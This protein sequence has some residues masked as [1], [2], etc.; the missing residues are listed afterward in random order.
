MEAADPRKELMRLVV[1]SAA[2]SPKARPAWLPEVLP[3]LADSRIPWEIRRQATARLL[4]L[5]PDRLRYVRPLLQALTHGLTSQQKWECLRW[6]QEAVPRCHALDRWLARWDQRRRW[7]CPRCQRYLPRP[8]FVTHLWHVH[9]LIYDHQRRRVC[10]PH[11]LARLAARRW[12]QT[13]QNAELDQVW[14]W[15]GTAG[16]RRCLRS[17]ATTPEDWHALLGQAGVRHQGLCPRCLTELPASLPP[18]LPPLTVTTHRLST[19]DWCV[20]IL[21]GPCWHV[22]RVR[23]PDQDY[24]LV[25]IRPSPRLLACLAAL[26]AAAVVLI[27]VPARLV[28]WPLLLIS[29]TIY[30]LVRFLLRHQADR[31]DQLI[32]AAW[33]YLVPQARLDRDDHLR[34]LTRLCQASM[35]QGSPAVR[36]DVLYPILQR[37]SET[38][39]TDQPERWRTRG[40][41]EALWLDDLA[42]DETKTLAA[43]LQRLEVVFRGDA[44]WLYAEALL[45]AWPLRNDANKFRHRLQIMLQMVAFQ[46]GWTPRQLKTLCD[47]APAIAHWLR[48]DAPALLAQRYALWHLPYSPAWSP[49][50]IT[51]FELVQRWPTLAEHWLA[52][53]PDLLWLERWDPQ[54]EPALGPII[55]TASGVC[56]AGYRSLNPEATIELKAVGRALN[57]DGQWLYTWQPLPDTLPQ[58]LRDWL[59]FLN[60][61]LEMIPDDTATPLFH[62]AL[63]SLVRP[64]PQ[65]RLPLLVPPGKIARRAAAP[66]RRQPLSRSGPDFSSQLHRRHK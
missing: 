60:D 35:G 4:R 11:R 34:W 44:P 22:T 32:D 7:R 62:Q 26:A 58:R 28:P 25:Q 2:L 18:E 52:E 8:E 16:L 54:H 19:F 41:A 13:G 57:Y 9:G 66:S 42:M 43:L 17:P 55:I 6:L 40:A 29:L 63:S 38:S 37:L 3:L 64:C 48:P 39:P 15:N 21:T 23:A 31:I 47:L 59:R 30:G 24:R 61:F 10:M 46:L 51:V 27:V 12:Q 49:Q 20:E 1:R 53:Y 56:L 5:V 14:L 33:Q 65:C 50:I 45:A 36:Q